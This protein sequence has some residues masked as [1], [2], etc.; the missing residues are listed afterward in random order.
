MEN[1][2]DGEKIFSAGKLGI[3][4]TLLFLL[5]GFVSLAFV[6][7]LAIAV[8]LILVEVFFGPWEVWI[9]SFDLTPV[10]SWLMSHKPTVFWL[11]VATIIYCWICYNVDKIMVPRD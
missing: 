9:F 6:V 4:C 7:C 11:V 2:V 8:L 3:N 10:I 1:V 5:V